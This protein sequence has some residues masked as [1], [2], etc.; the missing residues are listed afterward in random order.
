MLSLNDRVVMISGANRGIGLAIAN[1]LSAEGALVSLGGRNIDQLTEATAGLGDETV[2]RHRYD[3]VEDGSE[4]GWMTATLDRFGQL[5]G[6]VNSAGILESLTLDSDDD[7]ALDRMFMVNVK[8]PYR[9]TRAALPHL[10]VSGTGRIVNLSSLSGIRISNDEVGYAMSKFAVTA[11]SHATKR[12]GWDDGIRVT[13]LCPGYVDTEM[14]L[15]LDADLD[16]ST[17]VQ[18]DDLAELV[19]TVM[20]LPNTA[21]VSQMNVA[22]RLEPMI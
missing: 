5:D 2:L 20:R 10:R 6:L 17:V 14:P 4:T 22:C 9:L 8:G 13:N 3:A 7:S 21:A 15:A 19:S 18:P 12:A 16:G 1:R 11:L